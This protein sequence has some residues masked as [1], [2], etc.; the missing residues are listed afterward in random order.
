[1]SQS[2]I[3][4]WEPVVTYRCPCCKHKTLHGRARFEMCP[5]CCWEDDGQDEHDAEE[6]WGGPN[7]SL[8]LR[9]G[10]ENFKKFG[11]YEECLIDLAR[12]PS[13]EEL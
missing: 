6:V 2:V 12:K 1:V 4:D 3:E 7:G 8:S 10:Q 11:A 5:V 13:A 9:M